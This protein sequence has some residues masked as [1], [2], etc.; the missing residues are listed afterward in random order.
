[1]EYPYIWFWKSVLGQYKGMPCKV[2]ARGKM[3]SIRVVFEDG[4]TV[5]TSRYAV[6]KLNPTA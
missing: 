5:I 2:T 3:N 6:R 4:Y 1:M